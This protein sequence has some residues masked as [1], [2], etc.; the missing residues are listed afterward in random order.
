MRLLS[1]R[2]NGD[3]TLTNFVGDDIPHYAVLSHTWG[4]DGE[5][6]TFKDIWACTAGSKAGYT[7]VKFCGEN[8]AK[9]AL[10][11]FWVDTCCIDKS[12]S[13]ELQEAIAS[14]FRWY[15]NATKCYVY[16]SDVSTNSDA[17]A[18]PSLRSWQSALR[19]SRWF[20]R[21]WTLQELIAPLSVEFFCSNGRRLGDKVSLERQLHE[22]TG[23]AIP[24]LRG[25]SPS[26]FSVTERMSWSKNRQT[27][28]EEDKAYSLLGI[29]DVHM[30]LL[31][32]EGEQN[33]F[34]RL[35]AAICEHAK[36]H[37]RDEVSQA[38][39]NHTKRLK[40]SSGQ[41]SSIPSLL[42]LHP[43][44]LSYSGYAVQDIGATTYLP[45]IDKLYFNKIDQRLTSLTAAQGKTCRWFLTKPEYIS[46]HDVAQQP[47][48]GGFLWIKGNPGTGKSTLMKFL[49][50]EAKLNAKS[51]S[52][53]VT[54]S[55]FFLARGTVE[56]KSTMGLYRS[57]LHQ[58]FEK[59]VEL[60]ESLEWM[61]ADG[62]R[63][64]QQNGWNEQ[65]LK[66]TLVRAIKLLGARSLMIFVDALDEC[67][68]KQTMGMV[69]FFE[70]LCDH[71]KESQVR[72][73][74]CF[75]SRHY[76]TIVVQKG[77]EVNL[78]DEIGHTEDIEQYIKSNLRLGKSKQ[79]ESLRSEILEKSSSIFLWVV[80]VIDV[81]NSE[82]PNSSVSIKKIRERLKEIPP[83]LNDL[84]DMILTRDGEDLEQLRVCLKWILFT[85]RPLKPQ[86]LYF[87]IQLGVD[88]ES[89][90]CWDQ[91]D[92]EL[93]HIQTFVRSSSKGLAEVTRNETS[94]VQFI[95]E[96][97]RDF[98]LGK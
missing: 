62:A 53:Q 97:V 5:E 24:A 54:V 68:T 57:L 38:F 33:A 95:H 79:A 2:D 26:V 75:S 60:K 15:R 39:L 46:W 48:H 12:S 83:R 21:G 44:P 72:L 56:E 9:D 19:E 50:E 94:E 89:S 71:A 1:F 10:E 93:A 37:K 41:P 82:Y 45:L 77:I 66:Q 65:A 17:L 74:I 28:R 87:A 52:L 43:E 73:Q 16:L 69:C 55:F 29:F 63:G 27:K 84:F 18:D 42:D 88:K 96:S 35:S 31:Y 11:Y 91:E 20:T 92:V 58:L 6:V 70:E 23:I 22:I 8:A 76:P 7:K 32:G 81:L 14:M 40:S 3:L 13:T 36:K 86:E 85:A 80:L 4:P 51:N 59:A 78:E 30:P 49:F 25:T 64:I 47:D 98:L 34:E 61:T 90:G 67:D